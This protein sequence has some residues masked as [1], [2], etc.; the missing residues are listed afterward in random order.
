MIMI[1]INLLNIIT[2]KNILILKN[3]INKKILK[4]FKKIK[5][6]LIKNLHINKNKKVKIIKHNNYLKPKK[7]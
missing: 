4:L 1:E 6:I 7:K 2:I 5:K 3:L